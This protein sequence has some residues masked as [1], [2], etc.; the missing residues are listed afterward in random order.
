MTAIDLQVSIDCATCGHRSAASV[1]D[2]IE[3]DDALMVDQVIRDTVNRPPCS[4][5]HV[6]PERPVAPVFYLDDAHAYAAVIY[7]ETAEI[8]DQYRKKLAALRPELEVVHRIASGAALALELERR[9]RERRSIALI[10]RLSGTASGATE[11][12]E[13]HNDLIDASLFDILTALANN[14]ARGEFIARGFIG[15]ILGYV[16]VLDDPEPLATQERE[17]VAR[18]ADFLLEASRP[19]WFGPSESPKLSEVTAFVARITD[20]TPINDELQ[21]AFAACVVS[22]AMQHLPRLQPEPTAEFAHDWALAVCR[23]QLGRTL[24][25]V[26]GREFEAFGY[27]LTAIRSLEAIAA[28]HPDSPHLPAIE[29]QLVQLGNQLLR[30]QRPTRLADRNS[31]R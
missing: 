3:A 4:E 15:A 14:D 31:S 20:A 8:P 27:S 2:F 26:L 6:V 12:L 5:C 19:A 7:L 23:G 9:Q 10:H 28:A 17:L 24:S 29:H 13:Q 18:S 21:A 22:A 11:L 1:V 25:R 30:V 16:G